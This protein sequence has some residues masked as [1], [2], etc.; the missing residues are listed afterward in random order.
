MTT[1]PEQP[2]EQQIL[3]NG[4]D[5]PPGSGLIVTGAASGIGQA[6][7]IIAARMGMRVAGWDMNRAGVERTIERAGDAGGNIRAID[8]QIGDDD[9]VERAMAQTL[10]FAK[11]LALVN[12]A[13]PQMIGYQWN[14]DEVI[15][16]AVGSI[17][18]ISQ[19]F[20]RTDPGQG[21]SIVNIAALAGVFQAG[22]G[23]PW[24]AAAKSAIAGYTRHQGVAL[25][26]QPRVNAICPG[27]PIV[28]NRNAAVL[29]K[30]QDL[31]DKNPTGRAGR[32]E[33]IAA[34]ILFLISPAASYVNAAVIP[35]DGGLHMAG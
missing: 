30:M 6:T 33:E 11:P 1:T 28:T 13:G 5:N 19:A 17:H 15:A 27:G 10:E 12:N 26:G 21:S 35:I 32:P 7:A 14:F 29:D 24:Y 18:R 16:L 22:G 34:G 25:G 20:V 8:V 9:E 3:W 31:V 23:D 4:W 2:Y